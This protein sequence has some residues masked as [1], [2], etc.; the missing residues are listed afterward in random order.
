MK[1]RTQTLSFNAYRSG[2]AG[3]RKSE[4][5]LTASTHLVGQS[6]PHATGTRLDTTVMAFRTQGDII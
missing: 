4:W 1:W 5:S 3:R 6:A 2:F